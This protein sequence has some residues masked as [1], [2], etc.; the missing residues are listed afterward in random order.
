M[1]N[2]HLSVSPAADRANA[3]I[4]DGLNILDA[5]ATGGKKARSS[6]VCASERDLATPFGIGFYPSQSRRSSASQIGFLPLPRPCL[7]LLRILRIFVAAVMNSL[8]GCR[9]GEPLGRELLAEP[10]PIGRPVSRIVDARF[11]LMLFLPSRLIFAIAFW[12]SQS[13]RLG[14]DSCADRFGF[15]IHRNSLIPVAWGRC[16]STNMAI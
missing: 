10:F 6:V 11:F 15:L 12:I 16:E 5:E 7:H 3:A 4:S 2:F 8:E 14:A 13:P 1:I 9:I